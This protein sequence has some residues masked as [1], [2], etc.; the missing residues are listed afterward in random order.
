MRTSSGGSRGVP[1][2]GFRAVFADDIAVELTFG[3]VDQRE[4]VAELSEHIAAYLEFAFAAVPAQIRSLP[5]ESWGYVTRD[6]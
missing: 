5:G 2:D 6:K 1:I 3:G 4:F